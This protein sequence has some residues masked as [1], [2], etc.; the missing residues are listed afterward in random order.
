LPFELTKRHSPSLPF[1]NQTDPIRNSNNG[2]DS[3]SFTDIEVGSSVHEPKQINPLATPKSIVSHNISLA[4]T[5]LSA[6]STQSL[7]RKLLDKAHILDEYYQNIS[8]QPI[9]YFSS[10]SN[11]LLGKSNRTSPSFLHRHQSKDNIRKT[12]RRKYRNLYDNISSDSSRFNLYDDEDNILR[13]LIRF[14]NDIDLILSRL[15][16]EDENLQQIVNHPLL[17]ENLIEQT[18]TDSTDLN[19]QINTDQ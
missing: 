6:H 15:E 18:I 5:N 8:N 12:Q 1:L 11:S 13:E 19:P 14:N 7:L 10:S 9:S 17:D 3:D 4:T 2:I 16:N